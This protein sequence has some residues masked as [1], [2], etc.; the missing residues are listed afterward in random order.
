MHDQNM[1]TYVTGIRTVAVGFLVSLAR[2][3]VPV[4]PR[5]PTDNPVAHSRWRALFRPLVD[6]TAYMRS[7]GVQL[8]QLHTSWICL[9]ARLVFLM[10][11]GPHATAVHPDANLLCLLLVLWQMRG[12]EASN[13]MAGFGV[14]GALER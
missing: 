14:L 10:S 5:S 9:F 8:R 7:D 2:R 12:S 1:H 6:I 4:G 11:D 3:L 13:A